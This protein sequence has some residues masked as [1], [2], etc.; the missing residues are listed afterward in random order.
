RPDQA[1]DR[2]AASPPERV[3]RPEQPTL[4]LGYPV[5]P[6]RRQA[7]GCPDIPAR[8]DHP[9][10][11]RM[12]RGIALREGQC[13]SREVIADGRNLNRKKEDER[14]SPTVAQLAER[15]LDED[16]PQHCRPRTQVEC[17]HTVN[18]HILLALGTITVT[19]LERDDLVALQKSWQRVG[20]AA[21]LDEMR[22]HD[23]RHTFASGGESL[24][25]LGKTSAIPIPRRPHGTPISPRISCRPLPSASPC[26]DAV[27]GV[28]ITL[29]AP[30]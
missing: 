23:L 27:R 19:A 10:P 13:P 26:H 2:R 3:F 22:I 8:L 28:G 16:I 12:L 7:P 4:G 25:M 14:L 24:S 15:F 17:H 1:H 30:G 29:K 5:L 20:K 6:E 18:W 11:D 9:R 21:G